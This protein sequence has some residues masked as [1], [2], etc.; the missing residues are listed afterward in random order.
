MGDLTK[1]QFEALVDIMALREGSGKKE[2]VYQTLVKDKSPQEAAD[3]A[4]VKY[5][6]AWKATK[7]ARQVIALCN[8]VSGL[9]AHNNGGQE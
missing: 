6:D 9:P 1:K 3:I 2:A 5:Q 4:G 8:K 7:R